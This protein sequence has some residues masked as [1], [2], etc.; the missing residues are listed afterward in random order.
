[1]SNDEKLVH[2]KSEEEK[3]SEILVEFAYYATLEYVDKFSE[4]LSPADYGEF[5]V[6][7]IDELQSR[8]L[9]LGREEYL[10]EEENKN[11][12]N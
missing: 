10:K 4:Q 2:C 11:D 5:I 1:M 9:M 8:N 12:H 7:M 6:R 3:N